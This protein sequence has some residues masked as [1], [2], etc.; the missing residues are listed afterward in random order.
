M[1]YAYTVDERYGGTYSSSYAGYRDAPNSTSTAY[2]LAPG[3]YNAA[4]GALIPG[5]YSADQDAYSMGVLSPGKYTVYAGGYNWD[6]GNAIYGGGVNTVGVYDTFSNLIGSSYLGAVSFE[7][8]TTSTFIVSLSGYTYSGTEY[9]LYY[10][11][12]G[13][14]TPVNY[15]A[16]SG[17]LAV[18]GTLMVGSAVSAT[19]T[20]S[21][22]NGTSH[23]VQY[24]QWYRSSDLANWTTINGATSSSYSLTSA[25]QGLYVGYT[26]SFVDDAGFSEV[27]GASTAA[28]IAALDQI[29]GNASTT[30]VLSVQAGTLASSINSA[31][32]TDW[33]GANL[34][35]GT[36]YVVDLAG[37]GSGHGT[38]VDPWLAVRS[39]NG[40]ILAFGDSGGKGALDARVIYTPTSSGTY[41]LSA[42]EFGNDATGSYALSMAAPTLTALSTTG[43]GVAANI[44]S[45]GEEDWFV[46][47]LTAGVTYVF[48]LEGAAT[49]SGTLADPVLK[50]YASTGSMLWTSDDGGIGKNSLINFTPTS[51]GSYVLSVTGFNSATGS[52]RVLNLP[53]DAAVSAGAPQ[54]SG[55]N[56]IDATTH[57]YSWSLGV[58]RTI[59]WGLADSGAWNWTNAQSSAD[60]IAA[61]LATVEAVANIHFEY[62]GYFQGAAGLASAAS[63]GIDI[64]IAF[65]AALF[66]STSVWGKSY[67]PST[68][69]AYNP[70]PNAAGDILLNPSSL[71]NGLSYEPGSAGYFLILHELGHALGLKHPHDDGGTNHPTFAQAGIPAYLDDDWA[72]VMSYQDDYNWNLTAWDPATP[73]VLDVRALQYLYGANPQTNA[74]D[75]THLLLANAQYQTI[76]DAGGHDI[77]DAS[78]SGFGWTISF[79]AGGDTVGGALRSDELAL[80]SP[81]SLYWLMG[82]MEDVV[83]SEQG[84]N[85]SGNSLG[86]YLSG[87][88]GND[89]ISG[90]GG[91]DSME[92][93]AGND[94]LD[95]GV[96]AD[97]LTGGAGNDTLRG[98]DNADTLLGG[99]GDDSLAGG[100]GQDSV[101]GGDGNDTLSGGVGNDVLIGGNGT[102]RVDYSLAT[103]A[104]TVNLNIAGVA[105]LVSALQSSDTLSGIEQ[106]VGGNLGDTLT[107]DLNANLLMGLLGNDT[108]MGNEGFDTLDGG[109]GNDLLAG[110]NNADSLL[111]GLGNDTL[112]GG[113][114]VDTLDGG[115]GNDLLNG[116]LGAD[117]LTG[118]NGA[119][120]FFFNSILGG[121]NIDTITDFVSGVDVVQLSAAIFGAFNTQIGQAIGTSA[122]LSYDDA[123]GVLAYDADGAGG[124]APLAFAILGTSLHPALGL[125]DFLVVG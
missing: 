24:F 34:I 71:A 48:S 70:Y 106:V 100:K 7:V 2:V 107:G 96:G 69:A 119:D 77:V 122:N 60:Q 53:N 55:D 103:D 35:A 109:D 78:G 20:F 11:Y 116:T 21:D 61:I 99:D 37:S 90:G 43:A 88:D 68:A 91:S 75:T 56:L 117:L 125:S 26:L 95:G 44:S 66:S 19:G 62:G 40:G 87:N 118:G 81:T 14:L 31:G 18:S 49:G 105:Q 63:A 5:F 124:N 9:Q 113:K 3:Y 73:M 84:D 38:L 72:T 46:S 33:F 57:G 102:D 32:D 59:T 39:G 25:D 104:V 108:L 6:Y 65:D 64:S 121:G 36:T 74:G 86:N 1:A 16:T 47:N 22:Q 17:T 94:T 79:A 27:V 80:S 4:Y 30:A 51:S 82:A 10:T 45:A 97:S 12:D 29:P 93:G 120:T 67:F 98:A 52:Y 89:S 92:G 110:G 83:G 115:E 50:L 101:N 15:A 8:Y 85:I 123:T 114:G 42:E 112:G 28:T 23:A 41:Y 111:G 76:W 54:F 13:P 58:S